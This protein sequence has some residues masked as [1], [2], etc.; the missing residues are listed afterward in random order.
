ML[1]VTAPLTDRLPTRLTE[2][3]TAPRLS[4]PVLFTVSAKA[5]LTAP[6]RVSA[7]L[8]LFIL[9]SAA[10]VRGPV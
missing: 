6:L 4:W 9:V 2:V 5:P 10:R 3:P 8:P 7:P 1:R